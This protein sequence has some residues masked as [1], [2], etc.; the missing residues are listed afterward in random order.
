MIASLRSG[1]HT[2]CTLTLSIDA[3]SGAK[4]AISVTLQYAGFNNKETFRELQIRHRVHRMSHT[5][6]HYNVETCNR[7]YH[8]HDVIHSATHRL[9]NQNV[10]T[11]ICRSHILISSYLVSVLATLQVLATLYGALSMEA[12]SR[13]RMSFTMVYTTLQRRPSSLAH[14]RMGSCSTPNKWTSHA[15][16]MSKPSFRHLM[17]SS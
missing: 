14:W 6:C 12:L 4:G 1:Y 13:S 3:M 16:T 11:R 10:S 5:Q 7:G 9:A 17:W 2:R 15:Q 8:P